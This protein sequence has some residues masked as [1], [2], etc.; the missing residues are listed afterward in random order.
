MIMQLIQ[1]VKCSTRYYPAVSLHNQ[2]HLVGATDKMSNTNDGILS[3]L[4]R[5]DVARFHL[6]VMVIVCAISILLECSLAVLLL[7]FVQY[8]I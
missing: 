6:I 1:I 2:S 7:L 3:T 5:I 4:F 8:D